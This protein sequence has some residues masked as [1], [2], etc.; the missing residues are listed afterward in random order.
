MGPFSGSLVD[1]IIHNQLLGLTLVVVGFI[2]RFGESIYTPFLA[3][4]MARLQTT[5]QD[6]SLASFDVSSIDI[7]EV[8]TY[9]YH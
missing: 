7:G 1:I 9:E 2:L 4:G 6:T 3:V 8:R 5:L